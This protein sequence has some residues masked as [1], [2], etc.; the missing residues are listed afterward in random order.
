MQVQREFWRAPD[1]PVPSRQIENL[2]LSA[3]G[4]IKDGKGV[5][6]ARGAHNQSSF[7]IDGIPV[8][9]QLSATDLH[10]PV[11]SLQTFVLK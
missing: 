10:A 4:I 9:D 5:F 3:P 8:S 2:V 1:T 11:S 7:V 6:H